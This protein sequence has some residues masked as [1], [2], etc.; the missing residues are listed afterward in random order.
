MTDY[1]LNIVT[2]T[3]HKRVDGRVLERCNTDQIVES[4][5]YSE[6]PSTY[7]SPLGRISPVKPCK[8]CFPE[9]DIPRPQFD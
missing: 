3:L 5:V 1:L 6:P 4:A 8:R 7:T 2:K 9:G